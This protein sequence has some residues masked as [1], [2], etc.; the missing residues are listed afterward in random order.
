MR[1]YFF[2]N[3]AR[4]D[5]KPDGAVVGSFYY[6]DSTNKKEYLKNAARMKKAAGSSA[7]GEK[8]SRKKRTVKVSKSVKKKYRDKNRVEGYLQYNSWELLQ[9]FYIEYT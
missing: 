7:D 4:G 2:V 8:P 3:M 1:E 6:D 5:L 9:R